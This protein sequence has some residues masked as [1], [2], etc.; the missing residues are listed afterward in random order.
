MMKQKTTIKRS[1]IFGWFSA[2]LLLLA[3]FTQSQSGQAQ[4]TQPS[5]QQEGEKLSGDLKK[6]VRRSPGKRVK[7]ILDP[8]TTDASVINTLLRLRGGK[9][10][11]NF[12]HFSSQVV[13][14]PASIVEYIASHPAVGHLSL[15]KELTSFG[16]VTQTTGADLAKAMAGSTAV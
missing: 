14:L 9:R 5:Y 15:D 3:V 6:E 16:H 2:C 7:V 13:E 11:K 12:S 8:A 4:G 1:K 10:L